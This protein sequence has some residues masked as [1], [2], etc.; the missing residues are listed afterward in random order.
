MAKLMTQNKIK[1]T[2]NVEV[3]IRLYFSHCVSSILP[4]IFCFMQ[5]WSVP[6]LNG[7]SN[8][9]FSWAFCSNCRSCCIGNCWCRKNKSTC[10]DVIYLCDCFCAA[11]HDISL[12]RKTPSVKVARNRE[13]ASRFFLHVLDLASSTTWLEASV[14]LRRCGVI[15]PSTTDSSHPWADVFA[16]LYR[17]KHRNN[18]CDIYLFP[19]LHWLIFFPAAYCRR[20]RA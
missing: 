7:D 14:S 20:L 3:M 19:H 8:C 9:R 10:I 6:P 2:A 4:N 17:L 15:S 12:I 18:N 11:L 13:I 16:L 1:V 5:N